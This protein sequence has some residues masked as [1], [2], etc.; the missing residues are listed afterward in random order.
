MKRADVKEF[1][2]CA[3]AGRPPVDAERADSGTS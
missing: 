3:A 1:Q 2:R